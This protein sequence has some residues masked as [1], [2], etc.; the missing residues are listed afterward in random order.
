MHVINLINYLYR[1]YG[2]PI[3][4]YTRKLTRNTSYHKN[5]PLAKMLTEMLTDRRRTLILSIDK[6]SKLL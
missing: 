1:A 3:N 5:V 4:S 2:I 6:C